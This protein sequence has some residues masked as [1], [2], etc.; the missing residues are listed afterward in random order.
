[1]PAPRSLTD[2]YLNRRMAVLLGLG[3]ASGLPSA[4]KL[5][6]STLQAWLGS[7]KYDVKTIG[8]FTLVGLPFAF[9]FVWAPLLD[10]YVPPFL[11]RRRGWLLV[12]QLLLVVAIMSLALAGPTAPEQPLHA[13]VIAAL[14]VAFLAATQDV[15]ADA[16]RTDVLPDA[17]LGAG[18]AVFVNGYRI[19]MIFAGG[20]AMYLAP[21]LGW[22]TVYL[23]LAVLMSVGV[24]ATLL[25][26]DPPRT[27]APRSLA[28]AVYEPIEDFMVRKGR[29]GL[30]VLAFVVLFKLPDA[31]AN[32]MT[33]PLLQTGLGFA[34][35]EIAAY[36]EWL[37]LAFAIV[38]ALV[39]GGVTARLGVIPSLWVFGV[40]QAVSNLGFLLLAMAGKSVPML[41]G[42]VIVENFCAGLVA[43]GFIAFLMSQCNRRYSATQYAMFTSLMYGAGVVVGAATGFMVARMGYVSFFLLSV[44]AGV[45]GMAMLLALRGETRRPQA[46]G[47]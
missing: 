28:H 31:M 30:A 4:Y 24:L 10:R 16:Y 45:P 3:F 18:A 27:E 6:G 21:T 7:Y 34:L 41:I 33:M 35:E 37:G 47:P 38:G 12:I 29:A 25:A 15:V 9:N 14:I 22:R 5:L 44:V 26:P 42:V 1:M 36:R 11:G 43:A 8:L 20:G 40:L 13:L 32:A 2:I 23:W 46:A 17:E 19:A 39:G